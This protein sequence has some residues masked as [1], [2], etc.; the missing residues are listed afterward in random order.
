MTS[1]VCHVHC[2]LDCTVLVLTRSHPY[3]RSQ[4]GMSASDRWGDE[5]WDNEDSSCPR[6]VTPIDLTNSHR[7][8]H[9]QLGRNRQT[10]QFTYH[11]MFMQHVTSLEWTS[12]LQLTWLKIRR[13]YQHKSPQC[14][15]LTLPKSISD[16]VMLGSSE[17]GWMRTWGKWWL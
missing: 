5:E 6:V 4:D 9:K 15:L 12:Y 13:N 1:E 16:Q 7:H 8:W 2:F 17:R 10:Q 3:G 11:I 14:V